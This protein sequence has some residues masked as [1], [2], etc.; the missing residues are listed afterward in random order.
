[1]ELHVISWNACGIRDLARLTALRGYVYRHNPTVIFIQEAFVGPLLGERQAP[2]LS[3]YISYVHPVRN[4]LITYV[5]SSVQHQLLRTSVDADM[6]FQLLEVAMGCDKLRLCNVYSAPGRINLAALPLPTLR[7]AIYMGDFNARHPEL[8]DTS[9][10]PNRNGPRLLDYVRCH[11]LTRWITGGATHSR[12]GTLDYIF[13]SG[14]VASRVEC[15]SVP[16]LF[17]DHVALGLRYSV[18]ATPASVHTR[19]C[20]R[21][22]PKYCPTY[23]SYMTT[24]LPTFNSHSPDELYSSLV[25]STHEFYAQYVTRPHLARRPG[26]RAETVDDRVLQAERKAVEHGLAF[27]RNPTPAHLEMYQTSRDEL[28]GLQQC[29]QT[30]SWHTLTDSINHLTSV[31]SMWHKINR[32][33]KKRPR[34]AL[35]YSP[36]EYA[37]SLIDTWSAQSRLSHLPEPIQDA[38]SSQAALRSLRL[39]GALLQADEEDAVPITP[40]EL[41]RALATGKDSAPGEDGVTYSV[42]RLLQK[43]PGNPLL[44]LFNLCFHRGYVPRAWTS[45]II[46]PIPKP[47]T[48][49]FRPV[50]LT[51]CFSKVL[52]R[53]LLN[54]LLFRLHPKLSPHLYG[55]LPRRGTHHC[56]LELYTRLS[57]NSVVAFIDLKSAFDVANREIILDQ[58][59]DFGVKGNLLRWIRGYLSNRTARVLFRGSCST[60]KSLD[61][62]T[63]QG[64]VLSPFLFNVL[65]HRLLSLIPDIPGTTVTCYADDICIHSSSPRDLQAYLHAFASSSASCGLIISP[66]KSRIYSTRNPR[67][68]PVFTMGGTVVPHCT[69]YTYLGAPVRVTPAIPARQRIH[70]IVQDLLNRLERRFIPVKWLANNVRGVSIPVLKTIYILFLR[71]VIDYLSPA[72]CQLSRTALQP[73]DRF[74]NRVMRFIL[75]CPASTR[76]VN[77][78]SELQLMP[79]ADRIYANVTYLSVKCL[80]SPGLAPHYSNVILAALNPDLPTPLL[81]PGGRN[82]I[83]MVCADFR[84]LAFDVPAAEVAHGLPPWRVPLPVVSFTPTSKAA[85]PL[86]QKQLAL[87]TIDSVSASVPSAHHVYVDGSLQADGSA[88]CAVFSPTVEPPGVDGWA[89][90]RLPDSS[91]S[92]YCELHGLLDAVTLL[93]EKRLNGVIICDSKSALLALSSSRPSHDHVVQDI[94]CRL[95]NARDNA[96]VVSFLWVPS[97]VGLAGNDTVHG[98]AK[99]ACTLDLPV[100]VRSPPSLQC[101]K[102]ALFS[103]IH[104]LTVT[105]RDAE[106]ATSVSI[107]HYDNFIHVPYE[108]RRHGLMVRRHNVVSARLRLGYRPI[109]QISQ[110]EDVPH[111][112]TCRLCN[113]VNANTL[114]H[115]CLACPAVRALLPQGQDLIG[116]CSY[117]LS[118]DNLDLILMRYQYFGGC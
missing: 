95:A 7:G 56:L 77:M 62:G 102:Q 75:G 73:L 41:Q 111:Y 8:G 103:A 118:G 28:I 46:V 87:E 106:R 54:R 60:S 24:L 96:L 31:G 44:Q 86:L 115:Y 88:A 97:H 6:T 98:L 70:P 117:L 47:G 101:Y 22:P 59:V 50:S 53:I 21:I 18:P 109:W 36:L 10:T 20:I 93:T 71:S 19:T 72:L 91:S 5:H 99:A 27:Q 11:R 94:L 67:T 112:S 63:P 32:I 29:A 68:L 107:Q 14:L 34:T 25:K 39:V 79:L 61:L 37:Q 2:P 113:L 58:L 26:P 92:T 30:D 23:I 66:D 100:A 108:Y 48:D 105:R 45:S 74:Q 12:G 81:R 43:V 89:G 110:A 65:I 69:Q 114:E 80:H 104:A 13:T 49:R 78:L 4:G 38:L 17:S 16:V 76:T 35:H 42:L 9:H 15:F 82:L 64:G 85:H 55:F 51:S 33:I 83:R 52:E 1:M 57:P 116:V 40:H 84:R 3:G 90:R